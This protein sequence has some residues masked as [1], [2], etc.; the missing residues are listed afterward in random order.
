[1]KIIIPG[2]PVPQARMRHSIRGGFTKTYD[3]CCKQKVIIRRQM[4]QALVDSLSDTTFF[5]YPRISFLFHMPIPKSTPKKK[6]QLHKSGALKH[7]VKPDV[8]N[9]VKLYMDCIDGIFL[10]GD[11]CV[12]LGMC[13]KVYHSEP[14]TII[15]IDETAEIVNPWEVE[16]NFLTTEFKVPDSGIYQSPK[17][18][19][20]IHQDFQEFP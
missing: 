19:H 2:N 18:N 3:P 14:K 5:R 12:S 20:F 15:L 9:L 8:D 16:K 17:E 4:H 13:L 7:V 10:E 6:M 1:M 11:Q